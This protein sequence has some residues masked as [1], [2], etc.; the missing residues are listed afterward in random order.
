[1]T[2]LASA[3]LL[4]GCGGFQAQRVYDEASGASPQGD[5]YHQALYSGYMEHA[6]YE[7]EQMMD[8]P[9]AI[10]HS[11]K[12][13][14]AARGETPTVTEPSE[15]KLPADR[16]DEVTQA[17]ARLTSALGAGG[18]QRDPEAAAKAQSFYD[19]W[20]EQLE[21]NFQPADIA[22][23][24]DGFYKNLEL[25]EV[26]AAP[27]EV[28][29]VISMSADVLFDFDKYNIRPEFRPELDRVAELLVKDT[30]AN[31][32]VWGHTDTAGPKDYNQR[33]SE[34]RAEAVAAYL[35][36]RGVERN[37]MTV[38]GFGET[39]LAV[40]TPDNTPNQQNRRVEIRRR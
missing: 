5:A 7:Q 11:R 17:R 39:Q 24:R 33:L 35:E 18:V 21:E 6:T 30:V 8:Y 4:A 29:E 16:I 1:L 27:S 32:L 25:I 12:A 10:Y 31:V 22:Y 20:L 38:R 15:R 2:L 13:I 28:P 19:C 3:S 23:C 40:P 14:M 26:R 9:D 36:S 34:R 37:R